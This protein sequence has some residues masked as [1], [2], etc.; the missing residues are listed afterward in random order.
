MTDLSMLDS[1]GRASLA[2]DA[3]PAFTPGVRA[4]RRS[5]PPS[6]PSKAILKTAMPA[7]AA[8]LAA[9]SVTPRW[10]NAPPSAA[11]SD[12]SLIS[13]RSWSYSACSDDRLTLS[14]ELSSPL[15]GY[16]RRRCPLPPPRSAQDHRALW[17]PC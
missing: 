5:S 10:R 14:R 2:R 4:G 16:R 7:S 11:A 17:R 6:T 13:S 8:R 3:P 1:A 9:G 12:A 15:D